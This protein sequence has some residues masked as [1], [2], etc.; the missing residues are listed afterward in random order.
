MAIRVISKRPVSR[1]I[2]NCG[3]T[4]EFDESDGFKEFYAD[5]RINDQKWF[6]WFIE[7]PVCGYKLRVL[8]DKV[9][10]DDDEEDYDELD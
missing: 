10:K 9:T 4:L 7:C 3:A 1:K 5:Y 8:T 6:D 2:C